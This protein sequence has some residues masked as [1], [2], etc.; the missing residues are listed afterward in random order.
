[1]SSVATLGVLMLVPAVLFGIGSWSAARIHRR[2]GA[3]LYAWLSVAMAIQVFSQIHGLVAP[4]FLGPTVTTMDVFRTGSWVLLAGGAIAQLHYLY[5][6]RSRTAEQQGR[7]LHAQ[8]RLLSQQQQLAERE[9]I[10]RA[11][12]SHELATPIAAIRA[13]GHVMGSPAAAPDQ[14]EHALAG[15]RAEAARLA[16]LVDR[17]DELQDLDVAELTCDLRP[18]AVR[19]LL[20]ESRAFASGLPGR[21]EVILA[22]DD[23]R[24]WADPVRLG[25]L[26][27]NLIGNAA[28]Y[29]PEGEPIELRGAIV[30]TDT[31]RIE[32]IDRGP[33]IPVGQREELMQ[34]YARGSDAAEQPGSGLGLYIARRLTEAHGG[35]LEMQGGADGRGTTVSLTL[36]RAT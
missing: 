1:V 6:A 22:C 27:R 19:P 8:A 26:L 11:V 36:R 4:A 28:R 3:P 18:V 2:G 31:Y 30:D 21:S 7:D 12:V 35:R 13:F 25:Q 29:S 20:E 9:Q 32:V 34:P 33:G 16:E 23:D 15:L 10:F 17:I 24:T 5:V 14:R